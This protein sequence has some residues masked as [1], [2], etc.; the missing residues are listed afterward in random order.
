[1][2]KSP[3]TR[4]DMALG[5]MIR[6][7]TLCAI[8]LFAIFFI[9]EKLFSEKQFM[10]LICSLPTVLLLAAFE[11][12]FV[13][14]ENMEIE[15]VFLPKEIVGYGIVAICSFAVAMSI[16]FESTV[17][18][19]YLP[20]AVAVCVCAILSGIRFSFS[21][22]I[23]LTAIIVSENWALSSF[24]VDRTLNQFFGLAF[25]GLLFGVLRRILMPEP[26]W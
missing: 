23:I 18:L 8:A 15:T 20:T 5:R 3:V 4:I 1:M 17:W 26:N 21:F 13:D 19:T 16:F 14:N 24:D 10:M 11:A 25:S 9:F 12:F 7:F 6:N 22:S 2:E